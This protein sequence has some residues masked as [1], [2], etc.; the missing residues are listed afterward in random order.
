MGFTLALLIIFVLFFFSKG[1]TTGWIL[2]LVGLA[3]LFGAVIW[4]HSNYAK[5]NIPQK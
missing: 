3:A 1:I 5:K 4:V 2:A